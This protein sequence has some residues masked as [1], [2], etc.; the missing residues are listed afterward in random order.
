MVVVGAL[1]IALMISGLA[2]WLG[3][4]GVGRKR[5]GARYQ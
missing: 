4:R 2:G 1:A 5:H 3:R